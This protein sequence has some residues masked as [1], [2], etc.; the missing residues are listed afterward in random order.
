MGISESDMETLLSAAEDLSA[1]AVE[2]P[3]AAPASPGAAPSGSAELPAPGTDAPSGG[4]PATPR[5]RGELDRI[6]QVKVPVIVRL[7][8]QDMPLERILR[9]RLTRPTPGPARGPNASS[10]GKPVPVT[11]CLRP[12]ASLNGVGIVNLS[13]H[14]SG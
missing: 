6:L 9:P 14:Q 10:I 7:A 13:F 2:S 1:E 12:S 8:E 3:T 4:S 11:T 5:A